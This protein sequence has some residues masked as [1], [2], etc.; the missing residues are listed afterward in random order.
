MKKLQTILL[1]LLLFCVCIQGNACITEAKTK[2]TT[3]TKTATEADASDD[4]DSALSKRS[5]LIVMIDPGHQEKGNRSREKIGPG[6]RT[7]KAKVS[8][9]TRGV[10]THLAEYKLNLTVS[11][12][13]KEILEER[14]YTV[15]MTRE[16]NKVNI[17]NKQ[18]AM[19]ANKAKADIFVRIH[20]NGSVSRSKHGILTICMTKK[21]PYNKKLYKDSYALSRSILNATVKTTKAKKLTVMQSNTYTGIN[22]SKVPVTIVEMG[23]MS[24]AAED[25]KLS[26]KSY[27]KKIATGIANGIDNYF[28]K[29]HPECFEE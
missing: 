12:K 3:E 28:K 25:R 21:S 22:W 26:K 16:S 10:S 2:T 9:G 18:R 27:Q 4:E 15:L 20:A 8:Y 13:L 29:K 1:L 11:K 14:G 24:N 19:M 5:K 17:S 23:Y 7:T 6:A